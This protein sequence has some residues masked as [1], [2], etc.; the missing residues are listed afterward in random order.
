MFYYE[1]SFSRKAVFLKKTA[2]NPF[3]SGHDRFEKG[4]GC[5]AT[6]INITFS[7][8]IDVLNIFHLTIFSKKNFL[9]IT[10]ENY[11]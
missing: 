2:K 1:T 7:V 11:F 9:K 10:A 4:G 5:L 3:A 8:G 6:K